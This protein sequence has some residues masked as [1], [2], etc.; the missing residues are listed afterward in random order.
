MVAVEV[1]D[2]DT[3]DVAGRDAGVLHLPLGALARVEEESVGA[4]PPQQISVVVPA[5]G[6]HL[7]SRAENHESRALTSTTPEKVATPGASARTQTGWTGPEPRG[8]DGCLVF[9]APLPHG[10]DVSSTVKDSG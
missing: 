2:A 3:R 10:L 7:A 9:A 8:S 1:G 4:V 6:R 5:P